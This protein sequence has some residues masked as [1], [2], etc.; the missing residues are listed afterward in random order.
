M[1][2]KRL[3]KKQKAQRALDRDSTLLRLL[4]T[5]DTASMTVFERQTWQNHLTAIAERVGRHAGLVSRY[6][7]RTY[8]KWTGYREIFIKGIGYRLQ[9]TV[10]KD[11]DGWYWWRVTQFERFCHPLPADYIKDTVEG[12]T[13]KRKDSKAKMTE[14]WYE[15]EMKRKQIELASS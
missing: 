9:W 4:K 12:K 11:G 1:A 5:V 8:C 14:K 13:R 3:T 10:D 15:L 2:T 7:S 6:S